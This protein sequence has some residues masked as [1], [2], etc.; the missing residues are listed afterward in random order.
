MGPIGPI[1]KY[2]LADTE[3]KYLDVGMRIAQARGALTQ[4]QFAAQLDLDRKTVVRWESGERLPDGNSLIEIWKRFRVDPGWLLIGR[5]AAAAPQ[6][7]ARETS[8]LDAYRN[9][10]EVGRKALESTSNALAQQ[11]RESKTRTP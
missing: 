2:P 3:K 6:L 11:S 10:S 7:T 1:G 8:L 9:A 5:E 4:A